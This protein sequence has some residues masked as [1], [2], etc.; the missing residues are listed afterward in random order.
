MAPPSGNTGSASRR[1]GS[2][3]GGSPRTWCPSRARSC[4]P[5]PVRAR[6]RRSARGRRTRRPWPRARARRT[7]PP[8]TRRRRPRCA[9]PRSRSIHDAGLLGGGSVAVGADDRCAFARRHDRDGTSV[10][11]G[12]RR[13]RRTAACR[14]RRRARVGRR[15]ARRRLDARSRVEPGD[16]GLALHAERAQRVRDEVV[17]TDDHRDLD[18]LLLVVDRGERGP[19]RR[20]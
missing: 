8:R 20:R 12:W 5:N 4:R 9:L 18:Q 10:A 15:V 17:V 16:S 11:D 1:R 7:R 14:R 2:G 3:S 19:G 6:C 13:A